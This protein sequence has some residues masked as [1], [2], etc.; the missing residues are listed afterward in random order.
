MAYAIVISSMYVL[1]WTLLY[2]NHERL[3]FPVQPSSYAADLP[4]LQRI[5]DHA[6]REVLFQ[7]RALPNAKGVVLYTHGNATDIGLLAERRQFYEAQSW[8]FCALEYPGYGISGEE[9]SVQACY[10]AMDAV[11]AYLVDKA[12]GQKVVLHGRSLGSGLACYAAAQGHG[13]AVI[14]ESAYRSAQRVLLPIR[15]FPLDYFNN[16][17]R[18]AKIKQPLCVIHGA[19]DN[20]IAVSHGQF[21]AA[22]APN[23]HSKIILDKRDHNNIFLDDQGVQGALSAFLKDL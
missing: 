13:D 11:L 19:L 3:L 14:L 4:D 21:L 1:F 2:F 10:D 23:L 17:A 12:A 15:I 6:G 7:Y 9:L 20:V 5:K 22:H 16:Q 8:S 18:L